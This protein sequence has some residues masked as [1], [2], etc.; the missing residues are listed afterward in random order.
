MHQ[1]FSGQVFLQVYPLV[2]FVHTFHSIHLPTGVA[3]APIAED[4][5]EKEN[6][7]TGGPVVPKRE[8]RVLSGAAAG[9]GRPPVAVKREGH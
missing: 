7:R 5:S 4:G 9:T 6:G 3:P 1:I 2:S 8:R